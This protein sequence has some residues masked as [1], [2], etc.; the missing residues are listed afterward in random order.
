VTASGAFT[1]VT[2]ERTADVNT[3]G[4][5]NALLAIQPGDGPNGNNG[6]AE[7]TGDGTIELS[8]NGDF[9]D[10]SAAGVNNNATTEV[11]SV[12]NITNQGTQPV[13]IYI[14]RTGDNHP[15]A[16]TFY[17][18]EAG[19]TNIT[20]SDNSAAVTLSAGNTKNISMTIDTTGTQ[21]TDSDELLSDIT[22]YANATSS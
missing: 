8:L 20:S 18:G 17:E 21:V 19:G 11:D 12:L 16:V 3:A 1:T 6:Y 14:E 9:N 5:A 7:Q 22:I 4:D 10:Q 15:E 13:N 2:A